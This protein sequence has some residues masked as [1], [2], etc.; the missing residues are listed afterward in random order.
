MRTLYDPVSASLY[1]GAR[2][3]L[4]DLAEERRLLLYSRRERS[5]IELLEEMGIAAHFEGAYFVDQKDAG[6][7]QQILDTH[8]LA[9]EDCVVAG[10]MIS[11]ELTAAGELGIDTI[12]FKQQSFANNLLQLGYKPTHTVNSITEMH[13]LIKQLP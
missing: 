3:M 9:A 11:S 13:Q 1:S 8:G 10:D 6:N 4:S 7:L 12:W 2:A 5:R